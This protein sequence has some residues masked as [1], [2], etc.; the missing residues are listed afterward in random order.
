MGMS[1]E[2]KVSRVSGVIEEALIIQKTNP[3]YVPIISLSAERL[4]FANARDAVRLL[5]ED[6]VIKTMKTCWGFDEIKRDK[7]QKFVRTNYEDAATDTDYQAYEIEI[8]ERRLNQRSARISGRGTKNEVRFDSLNGRI[9]F[10]GMNHTFQK[11]NKNQLRLKLLRALWN[12]RKVIKDG[13][14]KSKGMPFP[15]SAVAVQ[16][17]LIDDPQA[18]DKDAEAKDAFDSLVKNT[19]RTLRDKGFP[20]KIQKAGGVQI[21]IGIK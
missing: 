4:G 7:T 2:E 6:G 10:L 3:V 13:K 19:V 20:V 9:S 12:K 15:S 11:G 14:V 17:G 16:L 5:R 1:L 21:V 18:F 8:D